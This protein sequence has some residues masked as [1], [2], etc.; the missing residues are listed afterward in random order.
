MIV[1][2]MLVE[3]ILLADVGAG[4]DGDDVKEVEFAMRVRR[5]L[6]PILA[7]HAGSEIAI[8]NCLATHLSLSI[9][10]NAKEVARMGPTYL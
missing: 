4:H 2:G 1:P 9:V 3:E 6:H 8:I 5:V 10:S 7:E